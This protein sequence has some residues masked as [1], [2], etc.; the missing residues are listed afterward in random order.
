MKR[1]IFFVLYSFLFSFV[2]IYAQT[3][4][5]IEIFQLGKESDTA[6]V[7]CITKQN[8]SEKL[9]AS[10]Y[11]FIE[12][13]SKDDFISSLDFQVLLAVTSHDYTDLPSDIAVYKY[14]GIRKLI[15]RITRYKQIAVCVFTG[16]DEFSINYTDGNLKAPSWL[17][18]FVYDCFQKNSI[19]KR[20]NYFLPTYFDAQTTDIL[21]L[22]FQENIPALLI[23]QNADFD[24]Y[25][26][27]HT[28][29]STY[30]KFYSD[31]WDKNYVA[32]GF[33]DKLIIISETMSIIFI[34]TVIFIIFTTIFVFGFIKKIRFSKKDFISNV[35]LYLIFFSL[36]FLLLVCSRFIS[37]SIFK[38]LFGNSEV[39]NVLC[40]SYIFIFLGS[41]ILLLSIAKLFLGLLSERFTIIVKLL[42]NFFPSG[43]LINFFVLISMQFFIYPFAFITF[44]F[45]N[46]FSERKRPISKLIIAF[47]IILPIIIYIVTIVA[48]KEAFISLIENDIL[49]LVILFLPLIFTLSYN[50]FTRVSK[51]T[52]IACVFFLLLGL[53]LS[54][55]ILQFIVRQK[56]IPIEV[57]QT[58]TDTTNTTHS[59]SLYAHYD[60]VQF[61]NIPPHNISSRSYL[62]IEKKFDNYLDRALGVLQINSDLM[63]EAIQISIT[64]RDGMPVYEADRDFELDETTALFLTSQKPTIPFILNFSSEKDATLEITVRLFSYDNPFSTHIAE[65]DYISFDERFILEANSSFILTTGEE[66]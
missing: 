13:S 53:V 12:Q 15:E 60:D 11:D 20:R 2:F 39:K 40:L 51:K 66:E 17:L 32:F 41:Y 29:I 61:Y 27:A 46:F 65:H 4:D 19:L 62:S 55:V 36:N 6:L 48:S 44:I 35:F 58:F 30:K 31:V 3:D 42:Q 57:R 49:F 25:N 14:M 10:V 64:R 23:K 59:L 43:T 18:E 28:L 34:I 5:D 24:F 45:S 9:L 63:V 21:N 26:I 56:T 22:F 50:F 54:T 8:T 7:L 16:D 52:H 38:I 33:D 1:F 47:F 37:D